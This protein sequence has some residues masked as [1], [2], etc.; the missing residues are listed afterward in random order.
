MVDSLMGS[1]SNTNCKEDVDEFICSLNRNGPT[2]G[3][4]PAVEVQLKPKYESMINSLSS[5]VRNILYHIPGSLDLSTQETNVIAHIGG[6][7]VKKIKSKV[8]A[9]CVCKLVYDSNVDNVDNVGHLDLIKKKKYEDA[10]DGLVMPSRLLCNILT[11][12]EKEYRSN[13]DQIIY[14]ES[15][16]FSFVNVL[17]KVKSLQAISCT[18]CQVLNSIVHVFINIRLHH[19]LKN[20]NK[21]MVTSRQNRKLLKFST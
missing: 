21:S 9:D 14:E 11:D 2:S 15:V 6:Y 10:K 8:C 3:F 17:S 16:K 19:S 7:I 5:D 12:L 18:L 20:A 4:I 1:S 13:I